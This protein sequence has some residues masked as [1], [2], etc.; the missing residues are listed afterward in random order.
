MI[1]TSSVY[2]YAPAS[3]VA[4]IVSLYVQ[5]NCA[6]LDCLTFITL[7]IPYEI[8]SFQ[9]G[10][11]PGSGFQFPVTSIVIS[12]SGQDSPEFGVETDTDAIHIVMS[13]DRYQYPCRPTVAHSDGSLVTSGAPAQPGE[14]VS[15]YA[16]GLGHTDPLVTTGEA[17]P[18]TGP[19][20]TS[21]VF[22][23]LDFRINARPHQPDTAIGSVIAA[24]L[25]PGQVGLYQIDVQ[26]P[27]VFPAVPACSGLIQSNL[28]INVGGLLSFDGTGI[29]VASNP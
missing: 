12:A 10:G 16:W 23:G 6:D 27:D 19:R 17:P 29:C 9:P 20:A 26:L 5:G 18:D 15:V 24:Y 25:A 14:T 3:H 11:L 8:E 4:P 22:V 7:Q 28:T 2:P 13:C 1:Q 21:N